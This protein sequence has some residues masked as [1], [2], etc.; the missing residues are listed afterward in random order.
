MVHREVHATG[1][2]ARAKHALEID[3]TKKAGNHAA[4][5]A[6]FSPEAQASDG[7]ALAALG[8]ACVDHGAAAAGLHADQEAVGA[9]A[10]NFGGLVG[11]FHDLASKYLRVCDPTQLWLRETHYYTKNP[12]PSQ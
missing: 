4:G 12:L 1:P 10:A 8:A 9:G 3:G 11:A 6:L 2:G 7:Q 5:A